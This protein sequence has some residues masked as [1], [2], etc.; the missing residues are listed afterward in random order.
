MSRRDNETGNRYDLV[1]FANGDYEFLNRKRNNTGKITYSDATGRLEI[2]KPFENDLRDWDTEFSVYGKDSKNKPVIHAQTK[3]WLTRLVWARENDRLSPSEIDHAKVIAEAEERRY[4]HV[5]EPGEGLG[6]DE[7]EAVIY[8]WDTAFRSGAL[9]LNHDGYLLMKDGRV[10][11]GL[12]CSPDMLDVSASRSRAPDSWGWWRPAKDDKLNRH[13]FSWPYKPQQFRMPKG[14]QVIGVPLKAGTRFEGDFGAAST[15]VNLAT[16]YSSVRWW[17]I[18]LDKN[19]RFLKYRRG[20]VQSGGGPGLDTMVTSVWNDEGSVTAISSPAVVSGTKKKFNNPALDRMGRYRFDGY[21]LT[22]KF[23][24]GRVEN[25][26]TFTDKD[27]TGIW[28]EGRMLH[29]RKEKK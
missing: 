28:F 12:P 27:Q 22:L 25:L 26:A 2:D 11:D 17:G 10:L 13:E 5:T 1:I 6:I 15:K 4:K 29:K 3:Y 21:R 18:K 16:E 23:D 9:Q 7:I 24:S 14:T 8:C 20:S 19:G